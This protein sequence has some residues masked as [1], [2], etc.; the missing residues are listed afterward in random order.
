MLAQFDRVPGE[1]LTQ[2]PESLRGTYK[3]VASTEYKADMEDSTRVILG[4]VWWGL[5]RTDTTERFHMGDSI[6]LSIVDNIYFISVRSPERKFWYVLAA[7]LRE[8]G[9]VQ[10][11]PIVPQVGCHK[12]RKKMN[13][14]NGTGDDVVYTM[15]ETELLRYYRKAIRKK[16][17]F[18]LVKEK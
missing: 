17:A 4:D 12:I 9:K 10:V 18:E 1:R 3:Q 5:Q 6:V 16:P 11:R 15:N 13:R 7:E 2:I 8:G 14:V